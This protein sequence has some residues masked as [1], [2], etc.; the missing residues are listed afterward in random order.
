MKF[1][2]KTLIGV[3]AVALAAGIAAG[4][5]IV[6]C[7]SALT[8]R[9]Y[10]LPTEGVER[11]FT[12]V[13]ITDLHGR[14]F[15]RDNEKLLELIRATMTHGEDVARTLSKLLGNPEAFGKTFNVNNVR[16]RAALQS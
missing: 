8:V 11:P 7:R 3:A 14:Q 1:Y 9:E 16:L 2:K 10:D 13:C 4:I 15:G 5:S 12:A 6:V